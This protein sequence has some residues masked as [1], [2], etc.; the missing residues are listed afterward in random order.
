MKSAWKFRLSCAVP[1]TERRAIAVAVVLIKPWGS[2]PKG[3][4]A[5]RCGFATCFL[6]LRFDVIK[7]FNFNGLC[8]NNRKQ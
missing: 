7:T 2:R 1:A 8:G 6:V 5:S 3:F 4:F